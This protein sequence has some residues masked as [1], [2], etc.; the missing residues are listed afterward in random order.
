[1]T[2][3]KYPGRVSIGLLSV[4]LLS[5]ATVWDYQAFCAPVTGSP[6][7]PLPRLEQYF[8]TLWTV[9]AT[10]A[11]M[12]YPIVIGFVAL[13][14][15][16][17]H[18]AKVSLQIYLHDS[19]AI[20]PGLSALFLVFA[21]GVQY[22]FIAMAGKQVLTNWLIFDG[23]WFL[24]NVVGVIWFLART[25]DYL[26]P[27]KRAN[28]QRAYAI[29]HVLP[30]EMRRNLEF[31][32]FLGAIDYGWLPGPSYGEEESNSNTAILIDPLLG[33]DMGEVQVTEQKKDKWFI[34]DVR[35]QPLF[36]AVQR[37]QQREEKLALSEKGQP[38]T[39][40]GQNRPRIFVLPFAPGTQFEAKYG[41]CR[42]DGGKG[43]HWWER[44][45]VR[46][47]FVLSP[48]EE[49]TAYLSISDILN[50]P[51]TEAQVA[52]EAGEE[53]S[54]RE[55]LDELVA[56]HAVLIMAGD[57]VTDSGQRNN[58][59]N[60]MDSNRAFLSEMHEL[61]EREYHRL[62][63][64]VVGRLTVNDT[65]F[66][67]MV[68]VPGR[69]VGMLKAV[70]PIT[71]P[72][73]FVRLSR[74]LHYRLN[75]WWSRTGEG[76]GL[77]DHGP[78]EPVTLKPPALALY[79]SAIRTYIGAWE[80]LKNDCFPPTRDETL[81]WEEY[82]EISE[83]YTGHLDSTLYMLFDSLSLGNKDGA[84]WLCDSLIKWWDTI[85]FRF[86]NPRYYIRDAS[87]LTLELSQKPWEEAK[88]VI[89]LSVLDVN[90][91]NAPKA[92]WAACIHNYWIDLCC[93]SLYAIIQLGKA[94]KSERSLPTQLAGNLGK[95]KALRAGG[96]AIGQHWPIQTLE[97]LLIAIIRQYY[98]DGGYHRGYRARL[99][100]VVEG[101]YNQS[102][103]AMVPGRVYSRRG[104]QDLDALSDGQ[105][106]LLCLLI[107]EGWTPSARFMETIQ[108]WGSVYDDGLR[109]F[110]KQLEQ[111]KTRLNDAEFRE[112]EHL[113]SCIQ[114]KFGAVENLEVAAA[115]LNVGFD[116][117]IGGIKGFRDGQLQDAQV[118]EERLEDVARW[119][120]RSGFSRDNGGIPV[121]LFREVQHSQVEYTEYSHTFCDLNKGEFVEPPMAQRVSSEDGY[122]DRVISKSV[123]RYVMAET[124][125]SLNP[126][127]V[128]VDS[129][130]AY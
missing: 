106:I 114:E 85:H 3:G 119:S 67:Y 110:K 62:L 20:L 69:L 10:I 109:E 15:Q 23:I 37:W 117:L 55:A 4:V 123:A 44:W 61:W 84:E 53:V 76:Q 120:S 42:T 8:F 111:W 129:P 115:V 19:A 92:L 112:Y 77:L 31:Y 96:D 13:L 6:P 101:I 75:R 38:D 71:I 121:S 91:D 14:L 22:F 87:K 124:L 104:A 50:G 90:E 105:L 5:S 51:I 73:H 65:Y 33:G 49:K 32:L 102:K 7:L 81:N 89:N 64:A 54:F 59:A 98:F 74:Y 83:L 9:Q 34:R 12:I 57:I 40:A 94:C 26:R 113:F 127:S 58:Y 47:S 68:H 30:A 86:D 41:L 52:I 116:K 99:N 11:A 126:K 46:R 108:K 16:R 39:F 122:F 130:L 29:N 97:D 95:G 24:V 88:N 2:A 43:L 118:S 27:E 60:L 63:N 1:M 93:V 66:D 78:C 36:W 17:R 18:S 72:C 25:F 125:K 35:F 48:K 56:L 21:M 107:K 128:D 45:L 79:D 80:S 70:R 103:P 82:G 28:I 100:E